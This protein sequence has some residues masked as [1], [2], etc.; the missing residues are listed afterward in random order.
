MHL[1]K[2][3]AWR[4]R[5]RNENLREH[6]YAPGRENTAQQSMDNNPKIKYPYK[7]RKLSEIIIY[8]VYQFEIFVSNLRK[9]Y[10]WNILNEIIEKSLKTSIAHQVN[11]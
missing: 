7:T 2:V 9:W 3:F 8:G 10:T 4:P 11:I 6:T 5:G 1:L